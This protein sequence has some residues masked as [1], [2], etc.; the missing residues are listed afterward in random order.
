MTPRTTDSPLQRQLFASFVCGFSV[1]L[2]LTFAITIYWDIHR[3]NAETDKTIQNSAA[4]IAAMDPVVEMLKNGY[5]DPSVGTMLDTLA[6]SF[7]GVDSI[8]IQ[9]TQGLR[10]YHTNR[11]TTGNSLVVGEQ[12]DILNGGPPY[13]TTGYSSHGTQRRAFHAVVDGRGEIIGFVMTSIFSAD[14]LH[15]NQNLVMS[16]VLILCAVF[17][18]GLVISK[19]IIRLLTHSL[20]GHH[21]NDLLNLYLRQEDV[22][23][24]L[25]EGL[26]ATDAKNHIVFSNHAANALFQDHEAALTGRKLCK[27]F[28]E[29]NCAE[30]FSSGKAQLNRTCIIGDR[31]VLV[32]E[33]PL[34]ENKQRCG[35][36]SVFHDKTEMVAL[37][38]ELSGTKYMLDTLRFFNHEFMNKLHIILGYLQTG[39]PQRAI[40]FIVRSSAV[41][42]QAIRETAD[43]IRASR[44]CALLIGKMMVAAEHNIALAVTPDSHCIE[45]D[46][47]IPVDDIIT[48]VGNLLENSIEELQQSSS[49]VREIK[50]G[51]HCR[52]DCNLLV[53]E[54]TGNGIPTQLQGEIMT[55]DYSSKG[56]NRGLGLHLV[57]SIVA[58]H[59]GSI[60]LESETGV[61]TCFTITFTRETQL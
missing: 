47:L 39:E 44:L 40:D 53:C 28:P 38:E 3:Q 41:S 55:R 17:L 48:I 26:V 19:N 36:L 1:L 11:K 14:I 52:P 51:I 49:P 32:T 15:R 43:C 23:N 12:D 18:V 27:C 8:L 58:Q 42:S 29:T 4:Y 30:I 24:A 46:L 37:S 59:H 2:L 20:M 9:N 57:Q 7:S 31:Q 25:N 16:Y 35:V 61:G 13:I 33:I 60:R 34:Y 56:E 21:P 50:L 10:F 6:Q 54:D 22:L 45:S 5:P